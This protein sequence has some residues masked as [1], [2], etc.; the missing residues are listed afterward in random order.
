MKGESDM[1]KSVFHPSGNP[2]MMRRMRLVA[3]EGS[4]VVAP[5]GKLHDAAEIQGTGKL[6][7]M[8]I[9]DALPAIK[10]AVDEGVERR[11]AR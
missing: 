2:E 9:W 4:G 5:G 3:D 7:T 10:K 1:I 6:M 11:R 8:S